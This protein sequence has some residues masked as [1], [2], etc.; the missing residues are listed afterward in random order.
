MCIC[1]N[2]RH[3]HNCT[4][5]KVIQKQHNQNV[6]QSQVFFIPS[7]TLININITQTNNS[8]KLDWDLV[9]CLSFVE[10]PGK[11]LLSI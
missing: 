5:Y 10:E 1:I 6:R 9:E 3:V 8:I 7:D 11:W 2:C 4:I